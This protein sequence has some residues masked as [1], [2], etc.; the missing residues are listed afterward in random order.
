MDNLTSID[1]SSSAKSFYSK[2]ATLKQLLE[3]TALMTLIQPQIM[4]PTFLPENQMDLVH[5]QVVAIVEKDVD[6]TM[7][8]VCYFGDVH[9]NVYFDH[10]ISGCVEVIFTAGVIM[11]TFTPQNH[12]EAEIKLFFNFFDYYLYQA[13]SHSMFPLLPDLDVMRLNCIMDQMDFQVMNPMI[14]ILEQPLGL[15]TASGCIVSD[16]CVQRSP[17]DVCPFVFQLWCNNDYDQQP[18][19]DAGPYEAKD[20]YDV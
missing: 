5:I 18:T 2:I 14:E 3:K 12:M 9:Y 17:A 10:Q 11:F 8:L 19:D 4:N 16:E 6:I 13:Y 7:K 15:L 1:Q 20:A